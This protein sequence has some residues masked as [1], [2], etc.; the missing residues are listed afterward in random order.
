MTNNNFYNRLKNFGLFHIFFSK[1]F[2]IS[3]LIFGALVYFSYSWCESQKNDFLN[4]IIS[5]SAALFSV[6]IMGFAIITTYTDEEYIIAWMEIKK[7]EGL[8][9]LFQINL[10]IPLCVLLISVLGKFFFLSNIFFFYF[11]VSIFFYMIF[12]LFDLI[13]FVAEFALMRGDLI[14]KKQKNS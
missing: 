14:K 1:D 11:T 2:L 5:V 8:I 7:Y 10:Y 6:I 12:A 3:V 9:T 4:I 13:K